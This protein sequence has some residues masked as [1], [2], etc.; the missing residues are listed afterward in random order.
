MDI[1]TLEKCLKTTIQEKGGEAISYT[2]A[3]TA[4]AKHGLSVLINGKTYEVLIVET[5]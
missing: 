4:P 1:A 5:C 2:N 3:D